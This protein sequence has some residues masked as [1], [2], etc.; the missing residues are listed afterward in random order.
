MRQK[1]ER[2]KSII[3]RGHLG[4]YFEILERYRIILRKK[5]EKREKFHATKMERT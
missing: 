4:R 2:D 3:R 5:I 1:L